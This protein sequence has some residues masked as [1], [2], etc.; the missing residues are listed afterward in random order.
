MET[1][2]KPAKRYEFRDVINPKV[3]Q[4]IGESIQAILP[5][6]DAKTFYAVVAPKLPD[7]GLMER[8]S[9]ISDQLYEQ[10]PKDFAE[11]GTILLTSLAKAEESEQ[12]AGND[13]FFFLAHGMYVSRYGLAEEHFELSTKFLA[14]MTKRFS[15]EFAIRPFLETHPERMLKVLQQ[16]AV[17]D[18]VH[19]RRLVSE[20]TRPRLP[21]GTRLSIYD[22]NYQPILDLLTQLRNDPELYVR[23]SVANHLNDL[24]KDRASLVIELLK[25]WQQT[26]NKKIEWIIKHALR[27]LIKAGDQAALALLGYS[28]NPNIEVQNFELSTDQLNLGEQLSFSFDLHSKATK[29]QPLMVDYIVYF[30]KANGKTAPKVFKLK[31]MV[32]KAGEQVHIQKQQRFQHYSTR[33][34]YP[35]NHSIE[36]QINGKS[37]GKCSFEL[38]F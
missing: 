21:W 13:S 37:Y 16:W 15:A 23:R 12:W 7:L 24:T 20:G 38:V 19:L 29:K 34:L 6:F 18:N 8:G 35:G 27:S 2:K 10:L 25:E 28:E 14:E 4:I 11:A 30:M 32:L 9:A 36:L 31:P 5:S 17:D 3:V 26:P 33:V 22:E 1:N